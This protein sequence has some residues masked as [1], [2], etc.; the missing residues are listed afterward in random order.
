MNKGLVILILLNFCALFIHESSA[1][2]FLAISPNSNAPGSVNIVTTQ[3]INADPVVDQPS[4]LGVTTSGY[5]KNPDG[6]SGL[7]PTYF[8]VPSASAANG[9]V[10]GPSTV[11]RTTGVNDPST[12][13]PV[14]TS[15]SSGSSSGLP[16]QA[17]DNNGVITLENTVPIG[18]PGVFQ[19]TQGH[20]VKVGTVGQNSDG[21]PV[22]QKSEVNDKTDPILGGSL[23]TTPNEDNKGPSIN[24][25]GST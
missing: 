14:D 18:A 3:P 19:V 4:G 15:G 16:I 21:T 8:N 20:E 2:G 12:S 7:T 1:A 11:G 23:V 22:L 6:S 10:D 13:D 5:T 24:D 17:T 9:V 25:R